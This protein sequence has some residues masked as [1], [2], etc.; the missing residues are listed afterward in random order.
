MFLMLC[1]S[2]VSNLKSRK[3]LAKIRT[4]KSIHVFTDSDYLP[5]QRRITCKKSWGNTNVR[6]F[7]Q[8]IWFHTQT[9][10]GTNTKSIWFTQRNS[11]SYNDALPN[12][13]S[14]GWFTWMRDRLLLRNTLAPYLFIICIDSVL[15]KR[16]WLYTKKKGKKQT[17]YCGNYISSRPRRWSSTSC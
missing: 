11:H 10:D 16:K 1:F 7:H 8:S 12:H 2:V 17:I 13:R 5:N 14:N 9:E 15:N 6:R 3:F 4:E